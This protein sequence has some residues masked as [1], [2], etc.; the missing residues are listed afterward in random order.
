MV[1]NACV[2]CHC[3]KDRDAVGSCAFCGRGF[4]DFCRSV[5]EGRAACFACA[6]R[7]RSIPRGEIESGFVEGPAVAKP[8]DATSRSAAIVLLLLCS[9]TYIPMLAN[10]DRGLSTFIALL[11]LAIVSLCFQAALIIRNNLWVWWICF[12]LWIVDMIVTN[13]VYF[14]SLDPT[15]VLSLVVLIFYF[16]FV[17]GIMVWISY[18][19]EN[20]VGASVVITIVLSIIIYAILHA[21]FMGY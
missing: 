12:V 5:V 1:E 20:I 6:E 10:W 14:H 3:H 18:R 7:W 4:C 2:K 17:I 15:G 21:A 9:I 13:V 16:P 8:H 19:D 11:V